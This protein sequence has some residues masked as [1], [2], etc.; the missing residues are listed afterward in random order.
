MCECVVA[1]IRVCACLCVCQTAQCWTHAAGSEMTASCWLVC[2]ERLHNWFSCIYFFNG[3][4]GR[5]LT[6]VCVECLFV[7]VCTW[8]Q[9]VHAKTRRKKKKNFPSTAFWDLIAPSFLA[10]SYSCQ[11]S[12]GLDP[13]HLLLCWLTHCWVFLC[14]CKDVDTLTL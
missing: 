4:Y 9:A 14:A 10:Q 13:S 5:L 8:I 6:G 3:P 11:R 2:T 7:R 1:W 12:S